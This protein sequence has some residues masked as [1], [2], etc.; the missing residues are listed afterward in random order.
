VRA[1]D[2]TLAALDFLVDAAPRAVR[3]TDVAQHLELSLA[4]ASRLLA[5]LVERGYASR[6]S[7]R[8]FTVGPRSVLLADKWVASMRAAAAGPMGRV[9]AATG[10]SVMLGQQLGEVLVPIAWQPP[11]QRA[12]EM[13]DK[14]SGIGPTFPLWATATGRA[15]LGK[16]PPSHRAKLLPEEF[17]KLTDRTIASPDDLRHAIRAGERSG[18]HVENGELDPDMWCCAVALERGAMGEVL[19]L[20]VISFGEPDSAQRTR[21]L[22]ALRRESRDVGYQLACP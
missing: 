2:R 13:V 16:L 3:A 20:A 17:P 15:M 18:L 4:T 19:A 1:A 5:A 6:T 7:E 9:V 10:E 12:G 21:I 14:L 8:K 11:R 22:S